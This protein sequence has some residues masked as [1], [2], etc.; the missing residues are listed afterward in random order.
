ME[1]LSLMEH[2]HHQPESTKK[3]MRCSR[4]AFSRWLE[5]HEGLDGGIYDHFDL[6]SEDEDGFDGGFFFSRKSDRPR[7]TDEDDAIRN[8]LFLPEYSTV[9]GLPEIEGVPEEIVNAEDEEHK[10]EDEHTVS[11][12]KK[13]ELPVLLDQYSATKCPGHGLGA[14]MDDNIKQLSSIRSIYK[15][16]NAI[17]NNTPLGESSH[18]L[19]D[20]DQDESSIPTIATPSIAPSTLSNTPSI[21]INQEATHQMMQRTIIQILTHAGFEA[22]QGGP[23]NVMT[24]LMAEYFTNI[25]KTVKTYCD[26]HGKD[27]TG[28]EILRH[29]LHE[30]G[31]NQLEDLETYAMDDVE[32]YGHRLK[33]VSRRLEGTYQE[34]VAGSTEETVHDES[35]LFEDDDAF[36]V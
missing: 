19:A 25:G 2:L 1:R 9:P 13:R 8:D 31:V 33:D 4:S 35:E 21:E 16:C 7:P 12:S 14:I 28:E 36:T 10:D 27:M 11:A 24:D 6:N 34:L 17:R 5:R 23:L 20:E 32:K 29:S 30:N 18:T 26:T 22:A 15:K 3:L